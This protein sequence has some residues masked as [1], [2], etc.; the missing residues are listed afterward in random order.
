[1]IQYSNLEQLLE[2][3]EVFLFENLRKFK[4]AI[5]VAFSRQ[6]GSSLPAG[7]RTI[8]SN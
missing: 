6:K 7:C 2:K 1:M 5:W 8:S 3:R 4:K